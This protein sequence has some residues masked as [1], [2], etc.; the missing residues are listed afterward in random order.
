MKNKGFT[1]VELLVMLIVLSILIAISVP[2]IAGIISNNRKSIMLDDANRMLD[3]AKVRLNV[4]EDEYLP[5]ENNACT[6]LRLSALDRNDDFKSGP[7]GG[8]YDKNDSFVL[9]TRLKSET[10]IEYNYYLRLIEIKDGKKYGINLASSTDVEKRN[11]EILDEKIVLNNIGS[12]DY[13]TEDFEKYKY[14]SELNSC[15]NINDV[16]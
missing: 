15:A 16:K 5:K 13:T 1:L 12:R 6:L 4:N 9:I 7:N 2:N 3:N 11:K 14:S 8:E 10:E